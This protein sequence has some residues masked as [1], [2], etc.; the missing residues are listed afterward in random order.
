[1]IRKWVRRGKEYKDK[2]LEDLSRR[3]RTPP[4]GTASRIEEEVVKIR[5]ERVYGK[6]LF[7]P[8]VPLYLL[9]AIQRE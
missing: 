1:V 8:E 6:R 9:Y 2:G 7:G 5:K 3:P 4:F